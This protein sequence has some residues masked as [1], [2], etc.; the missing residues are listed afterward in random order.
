[1]EMQCLLAVSRE[2]VLIKIGPGGYLRGGG[3]VAK[4]GQV[5]II[6]QSL[7]IL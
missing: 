6:T 5:G 4:T 7:T 1:M 2:D 3:T